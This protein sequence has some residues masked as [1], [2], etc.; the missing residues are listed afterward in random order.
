MDAA[1]APVPECP[2]R[3]AE[4]VEEKIIPQII[5]LNVGAVPIAYQL[6]MRTFDLPAHEQVFTP[7][8]GVMIGLVLHASGYSYSFVAHQRDPYPAHSRTMLLWR[9]PAER[10]AAQ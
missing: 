10:A 4:V 2:F 6:N 7:L 5:A 8:T 9:V 3:V 1:A